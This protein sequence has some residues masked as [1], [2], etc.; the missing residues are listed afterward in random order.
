MTYI[1][2]EMLWTP[3]RIYEAPMVYSRMFLSF[4]FFTE[5]L[6]AHYSKKTALWDT[7]NVWY[8]SL[9]VFFAKTNWIVLIIG[10]YLIIILFGCNSTIICIDMQTKDR[11]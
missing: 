11:I 6:L 2:M 7:S 10:Y 5:F 1:Q 3:D 8:A 4:A 9:L